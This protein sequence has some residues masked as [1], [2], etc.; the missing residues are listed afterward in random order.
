MREKSDRP[1]TGEQHLR[2]MRAILT[3]DGVIG[4]QF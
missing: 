1:G 4:I 3:S 2:D